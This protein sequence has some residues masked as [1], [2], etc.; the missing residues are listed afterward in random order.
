MNNY[1]TKKIIDQLENL[2]DS[3]EFKRKE[4]MPQVESDLDQEIAKKFYNFFYNKSNKLPTYEEI[5]E[6]IKKLTS[7]GQLIISKCKKL[8]VL[9]EPDNNNSIILEI[10]EPYNERLLTKIKISKHE[11]SEAKINETRFLP[12]NIKKEEK[13]NFEQIKKLKEFIAEYS[14]HLRIEQNRHLNK[15]ET[16]TVDDFFMP[17]RLLKVL[18]AKN[19]KT[20]IDLYNLGE[21]ELKKLNISE[22]IFY[23]ENL[24]IIMKDKQIRE[25]QM[26]NP[27]FKRIRFEDFIS[28]IEVKNKLK[29]IGIDTPEKLIKN[30]CFTD[31]PGCT[32][33]IKLRIKEIISTKRIKNILRS[34]RLLS[35]SLASQ[36]EF[37]DLN[38]DI[39]LIKKARAYYNI[40]TAK[41]LIEL[42]LEDKFIRGDYSLKR[43][44]EKEITFEKVDQILKKL[45]LKQLKEYKGK[46]E[47]VKGKQKVKK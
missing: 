36:I 41:E 15:Y 12:L 8:N 38:M 47:Q 5:D 26:E 44:L 11:Y 4:S 45:K 6:Q 35:T 46:L 21:E 10:I 3:L 31:I 39:N 18:K 14:K 16:I 17:I 29:K 40:S 2:T 1:E 19:V 23:E 7:R 20:V 33:S 25:Q 22:E 24:E 34:K 42:I 9:K 13:E 30:L 43:E 32:D 27:Y 37:E 28:N